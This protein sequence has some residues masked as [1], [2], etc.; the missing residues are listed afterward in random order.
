MISLFPNYTR[1]HFLAAICWQFSMFFATQMIFPIFSSYVP[2]WRCSPVNQ[3]SSEPFARNCS[4]FQQC[5][6]PNII[7]Y[8]HIYFQS[9]ALEF[10]L[11]CG[12]RRYLAT[13]YAQIQFVG[14][15]IGTVSF[16][17]LSDCLGRRPVSIFILCFGIVMTVISGL[18]PNWLLFTVSRF[19][20]GLS[21]GGTIV[22]VNTFVMEMLLPEQR[23]SVRA[24][25]NWGNARLMLTGLCF[26][27]PD[28]RTASFACAICSLPALILVTFVFPEST[29]WLHSKHDPVGKKEGF[30]ELIRDKEFLH[31]IGV[32]WIMWFTASASS[33]ATDL[34]SSRIV[35]N[36]FLNQVL[37]SVFLAL[38]KNMLV[39]FDAMNF[40]RRNLH[41]F[42]Q[43]VVII[44]FLTLSTLALLNEHGV[45]ILIVN[46]LGV[47]CIEYTW[48]ACYLC[49]VESMPTEMRA[50][51][52]GSCSM[53]ARI[54]A[55][56]APALAFMN[57]IWAPSAYLTIC[58][59]GSISLFVSYN[60]LIETRGINLDNVKLHEA[61][62]LVPNE[63]ETDAENKKFLKNGKESES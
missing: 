23:I 24:F 47:V 50:S 3:T 38:S 63:N 60:W 27:F 9:A 16:G 53:V 34:S 46:L 1:F 51:A 28:W 29:T 56:M 58:F 26:L 20:V 7:E 44:C 8:E 19:F 59:L 41:Q 52:M 42:A 36:L 5:S 14:V 39:P 49:A 22:V 25:F 4:A 55:V 13:L 62:D 32:L 17:S 35:G 45:S 48:D 61:G 40:S 57:T 6:E 54:G 30:C 10:N 37:F 15:L 33:Y 12:S 21:N 2:R 43:T 18:S 31:R 11:I